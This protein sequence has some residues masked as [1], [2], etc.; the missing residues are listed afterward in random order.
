MPFRLKR[1]ESAVSEWIGNL[2]YDELASRSHYQLSRM[3]PIPALPTDA[4]ERPSSVCDR[5]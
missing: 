2:S 3:V 1:P 4:V 5:V